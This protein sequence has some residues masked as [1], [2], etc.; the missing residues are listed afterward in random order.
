MSKNTRDTMTDVEHIREFG[1]QLAHEFIR[2]A[3]SNIV[4]IIT[5]EKHCK[6]VV[7]F[8]RK[9]ADDLSNEEHIQ[10][11]L[12]KN[13]IT[14][15][16]LYKLLSKDTYE[17]Y[18]EEVRKSN[19]NQNLNEFSL[20]Q[21]WGLLI[22]KGG[23][24]CHCIG[25]AFEMSYKTAIAREGTNF[26]K[27]HPISILHKQLVTSKQEVENIILNH[28]WQ[29]IEAFTSYFDE[30]FSDPNV[31]YF[32]KYLTFHD[33]EYKHPSQLI[34]LFHKIS[35]PMRKIKYQGSEKWTYP[36]RLLS[37]K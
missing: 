36:I 30:Y 31:K 12:N 1:F 15:D 37:V 2:V 25:M 3:E 19:I 23:L 33:E 29:S 18:N 4:E 7:I 24:V 14:K 6:S 28:G 26:E 13:K 34:R 35:E 32:E 5:V 11:Q 27:R 20:A 10:K 22:P 9:L 21:L 16:T 17:Y 8:Q